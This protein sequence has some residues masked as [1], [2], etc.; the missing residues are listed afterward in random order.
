M[1]IQRKRDDGAMLAKQALTYT[2]RVI[3]YVN[4]VEASL[5]NATESTPARSKIKEEFKPVTQDST[6]PSPTRLSKVPQLIFTQKKRLSSRISV[7]RSIT[8]KVQPRLNSERTTSLAETEAILTIPKVETSSSDQMVRGDGLEVD[9]EH[10]SAI[11]DAKPT[12]PKKRPRPSFPPREG[13][14][15]TRPLPH[16]P[17]KKLRT[18][19]LGDLKR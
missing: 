12:K 10:T 16:A 11:T 4:K 17:S 18:F 5:T 6:T 2:S 1:Y 19:N 7:T 15:Y 8:P 13:P 9:R 3:Q 14:D